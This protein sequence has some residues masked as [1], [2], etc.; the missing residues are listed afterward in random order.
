VELPPEERGRAVKALRE[1][2]QGLN[3]TEGV[4]PPSLRERFDAACE[5][6]W[7]P[8]R[9]HMAEQAERR[10]ANLVRR[11]AFL[12]RLEEQVKSLQA[13]T[14]DWRAIAQAVSEAPSRWRKFGHVSRESK[15]VLE[16]RFEAAMGELDRRLRA[17]VAFEEREREG[18]ISRAQFVASKPDDKELVARIRALQSDWQQRTRTVPL[19]RDKEQALWERFSAICTRTSRD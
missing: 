18:L 5:K 11:E 8:V 15:Q 12:Q 16:A 14:V 7:E 4:A 10:A 9:A 2:W 13:P 6:A 1:Q 19:E 17:V 3:Q